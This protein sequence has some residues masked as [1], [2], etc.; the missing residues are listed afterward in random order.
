M[1]LKTILLFVL[2][3][4]IL[5]CS[6]DDAKSEEFHFLE[7]EKD[8]ILPS[9]NSGDISF[10][11]IYFDT[12]LSNWELKLSD[13]SGNVVPAELSKVEDTRFSYANGASLQKISFKAAPKEE[14]VYTL[15]ITNRTTNQVYT[16]H[17]L[18]RSK[19]FN[20]IEYPYADDYTLLF[21]YSSDQAKP[22]QDFIYFH[23]VKNTI[24]S[25]L[26]TTGISGI[27]LEE[28]TTFKQYNIDYTIDPYTNK[29]EFAI[30]EGVPAGKYYLSVRYNN[31]TEAYFEKDIVVQ[32][33]KLPV[34]TSINKNTFKAGEIMTIKG[35]NFR[36][37]VNSSLLPN[38][39]FGAHMTPSS[40]EVNTGNGIGNLDLSPYE[41]QPSFKYMNVEGTEINFPIPRNTGPDDFFY[42]SDSEGTY[43]EGTI[44][45]R[46]G[47][48]VS[49]PVHVRI[50]FK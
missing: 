28:T 18:V 7:F 20:E 12:K 37:K 32:E 26:L 8:I 15:I 34:I 6:S 39:I 38:G 9:A 4:S 47:P 30:P 43:F 42:V 50:E 40:L 19:T 35:M 25:T 41:S 21:A 16:D 24:K 11:A 44:A 17:F 1:K 10:F 13:E 31:L 27:R 29:I 48:F 49:E 46:T 45:V 3:L 14:G 5:S 36:Y 33:E 22:T 23:N 2:S